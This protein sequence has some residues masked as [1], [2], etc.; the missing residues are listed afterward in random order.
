MGILIA[1][2]LDTIVSPISPV[3]TRRLHHRVYQFTRAHLEPAVKVRETQ[4]KMQ[5]HDPK[6]D[7]YIC[8]NI[9]SSKCSQ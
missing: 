6:F 9:F 1:D 2:G 7:Q 8:L 3:K 5:T 4:R